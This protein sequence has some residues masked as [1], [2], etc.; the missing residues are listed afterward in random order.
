MRGH[1]GVLREVEGVVVV[2]QDLE[3]DAI[4]LLMR[5]LVEPRE[6]VFVAGLEGLDESIVL[7]TLVLTHA[8]ILALRGRD[9]GASGG[10]LDKP[11]L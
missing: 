3:G 8:V 9:A 5:A 11:L 1:E 10:R 7:L 2:A 4:D 6:G